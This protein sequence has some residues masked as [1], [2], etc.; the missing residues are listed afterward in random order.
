MDPAQRGQTPM[1][2]LPPP[3]LRAA[4]WRVP[5]GMIEDVATLAQVEERT[6]AEM[7]RILLDL[8]L[9][10]YRPRNPAAGWQTRDRQGRAD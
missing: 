2:D 3:P 6:A 1:T 7:A 10:H 5:Q 9:R 4:P 8:A